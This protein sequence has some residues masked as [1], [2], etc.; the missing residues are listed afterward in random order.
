MKIE[1]DGSSRQPFGRFRYAI[2]ANAATAALH[3]PKGFFEM[4]DLTDN[5]SL[6]NEEKHES[7]IT[8]IRCLFSMSQRAG[9]ADH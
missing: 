1:G 7:T 9:R 5:V 8:F 6:T 2:A 4:R 3:R